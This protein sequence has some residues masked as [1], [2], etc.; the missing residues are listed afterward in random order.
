MTPDETATN[1][2]SATPSRSRHAW[3]SVG[4]AGFVV[5]LATALP[6]VGAILLLGTV[7]TNATFFE[8]ESVVT[9]LPLLIGMYLAGSLLCGTALLPTHALS[10][11]AGWTFGGIIGLLLA[12]LAVT[13]ASLLGYIL[14]KTLGG[15]GLNQWMQQQPKLQP[16]H[17]ALILASPKRTTILI[18]LLRLSPVMPFA[19]TN[20]LLA[21]LG[22]RLIPFLI[23]TTIGMFPRVAAVVLLGAGLEQLEFDQPSSFWIAI[24]GV[25]ASILFLIVASKIAYKASQNLYRAS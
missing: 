17:H 18:A 9:A 20:A 19:A 3:L 14:G 7:I 1:S 2:P 4:R 16:I 6:G 25:L 13:T 5:A 11:L 22:I 23:G 8:V 24:A 21:T 12:W 10:L 15:D